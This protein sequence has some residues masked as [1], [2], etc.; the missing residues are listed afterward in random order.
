MRYYE[1]ERD[2]IDFFR[3][4]YEFLSNFYPTKMWYEGILYQNAEAAYQ[5]QKCAD[6]EERKKFARLYSD[7]AKRLGREVAVRSDWEYVKVPVMEQ[8]VRAKFTQHP[9]LAKRL[10]E[11]GDRPLFEGN[12]WHDVFW[13]IDLRT[14]EG[15]NHLG[16][17]T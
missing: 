8:I 7:E 4:E 11:T 1:Q 17:I 2:V 12:Y 6:P 10:M 14:R 3:E 16:I 13:G 9:R 15:E 5:A